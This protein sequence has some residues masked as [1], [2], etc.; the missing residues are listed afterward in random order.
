MTRLGHL[1]MAGLLAVGACSRETEKDS[2]RLSRFITEFKAAWLFGPDFQVEESPG[3]RPPAVDAERGIYQVNGTLKPR[4]GPASL[5]DVGNAFERSTRAKLKEL[6]LTFCDMGRLVETDR[7][8]SRKV[9]YKSDR[10]D[11]QVLVELRA[12]ADGSAVAY[13]ITLQENA[14]APVDTG[15]G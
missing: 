11:G 13:S 3:G 1:A 10:V 8:V 5:R 15:A 7:H 14:K 6:G 4:G 9:T 2:P 12:N